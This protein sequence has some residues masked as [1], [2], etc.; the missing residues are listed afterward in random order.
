[1]N[2]ETKLKLGD[3]VKFFKEDYGYIYGVVSSIGV[4]IDSDGVE[5][6]YAI[7]HNNGEKFSCRENRLEKP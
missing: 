4:F 5:I 1:M 7:H 2:I 3:K 6:S